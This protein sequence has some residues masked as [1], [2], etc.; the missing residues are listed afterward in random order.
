MSHSPDA[1]CEGARLARVRA[2]KLLDSKAELPFDRITALAARLFAAPIAMVSL[3]DAQRQWFKSRV[4]LEAEETARCI[5][6]CTHAIQN[7]AVFV[8]PDATLDGRFAANPLVTGAPHIRFYAGAP[9]ITADGF[10]LGTLCVI[11]TVPRQ[12]F[13]SDQS[14][15]LAD[16]AAMVMREIELREQLVEGSAA[17]NALAESEQRF[18]GSMHSAA[19]GV[20][21]VSPEGKFLE[22]NAALASFL[23]Y[24]RAEL[25]QRTFQELT[26]P[27]DLEAD[28]E[29]AQRLLDG[30]IESYRMEKRYIRSDGVPVWGLLAVSLVRGADGSPLHFVAQVQDVSEVHRLANDLL[31]DKEILLAT[32]LNLREARVEADAANRAKSEFLAIMSHELRTPLTAVLGFSQLLEHELFGT[33]NDKQQEFVRNILSSGQ[34]L[35]DL[36]NDILELS[37]VEAGRFDLDLRPIDPVVVLKASLSNVAH[38]ADMHGIR[39]DEGAH[40]VAAP[41]VMADQVRL[42]QVL[43]NLLTNAIKYNNPGGSVLPVITASEGSVTIAVTDTGKG[44]SPDRQLELFEPFARLGAENTHVE[45]HGIGLALARRLVDLMGGTIGVR[46]SPGHGS[47]FWVTLPAAAIAPEIASPG[48]DKMKTVKDLRVLHIEDNSEI[49]S[50]VRHFSEAHPGVSLLAAENGASGVEI[51]RRWKPDLVLLDLNLPDMSGIE[52]I[53]RIKAVPEM[54]DVPITVASASSRA[55]QVRQAEQAGATG[56]LPKP[57]NLS[58][59]NDLFATT[60]QLQAQTVH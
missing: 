33:L 59:L 44:I 42:S 29:Q 60:A 43:N 13:G 36:I 14:A 37:K 23:G 6:F 21:L 1:A 58:Q 3:I 18:R 47:T 57:L 25:Q 24:S 49:R 31:K 54:H 45:G 28:L 26:H 10:K 52:V 8:V 7:D 4:G 12:N 48:Q 30:S 34:L 20:A 38:L 41:H 46:S 39:L 17:K 9:L 40:N 19:V 15:T 55:E 27:E 51:A 22:V 35:L 11:D 56:F 53:R 50:L 5:S 2:T 32:A 16:L